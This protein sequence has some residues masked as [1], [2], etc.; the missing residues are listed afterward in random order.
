MNKKLLPVTSATFK[1]NIFIF[2]LLYAIVVLYLP[3]PNSQNSAALFILNTLSLVIFILSVLNIK[4]GLYLFIFFT[5]LLGS[6]P[7][8]ISAGDMSFILYLFFALFLGFFVYYSSKTHSK[9]YHDYN[10]AFVLDLDI[11]KVS[12][13]FIIICIAS[14]LV[15]IYRYANFVP[16]ITNF[17]H[18]LEVNINGT[19]ST[20]SILWTIDYFFSYIV[21]FGL[22][23][24]VFNTIKKNRDI[25]GA[26]IVLIIS[27]LISSGV[28][29]YQY[30]INPNLG[31]IDSW[32]NSGRFNATFTDPNALGAYGILLFP[33]FISLLI[34]FKKWYLKLMMIV[35]AIP[36]M[37]MIFLSGSRSIFIGILITILFL[38]II[39]VTVTVRKM[40]HYSILKKTLVLV[41]IS[42]I[43]LL[44]V[45]FASNYLTIEN[46]EKSLIAK[47]GLVDRSI[48]SL[49]TLIHYY[50][51]AG[52][53]ESLKS[54]SNFRYV[55]W[56]RAIEMFQDHK[57][58][59]VGVGSYIIELP[60][61]LLRNFARDRGATRNM[62]IDFTGNYYLQL[63]SELGA[64][65]LISIMLIF[66]LLINR[67]FRYFKQK[68]QEKIKN[69]DWLLVGFFLGYISMLFG[70]IFGP[71]TNFMEIQF[72][73]WLVIGLMVAY[74]NI[75]QKTRTGN[76]NRIAPAINITNKLRFN[77]V[78][79]VSFI[80]ITTVFA[81]SFFISSITTLS[82][83]VNQNSYNRWGEY[84]GWEN[85]YGF[86]NT[87]TSGDREYRLA[88]MDASEVLEKQGNLLIV[89][90]GDTYPFDDRL[91]LIVRIYVDNALVRIVK[92]NDK[93]WH[94]IEVEIPDYTKGHFT[95]TFVSSRS[96][97]P[98]E[99]GQFADKRENALVIGQ[100]RWSN[101]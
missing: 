61:Y 37:A 34:Y 31:S 47:S 100:Y 90:M 6:I 10:D 68:G 17:Y 16:F 28:V 2:L 88:K 92:L 39:G 77:L 53:V 13:L 84:K 71:H 41:S 91:P 32:V 74:I 38:I 52:L 8:I 51:S 78:S 99:Y 18:N 79:K 97:V 64:V 81:F 26:V 35:L 36:L 80:F 25:F 21:G 24:V 76:S 43:C 30:F 82:I 69:R 22:L 42:I 86:Y 89:P 23:L 59:G 101:Q 49:K 33:I 1:K 58:S 67:V 50:Q 48:D 20:A 66:Y 9:F 7:R 96:W 45:V 70:L 5:P 85:Y 98:S 19:T 83:N 94:D 87:E 15:T 62:D 56:G 29:F 93:I 40:R 11:T 54:I 63:L 55:Y 12:L 75:N 72:T 73:F 60:N 3:N 65:G 4:F 95:I 57:I 46:L 27:T 44:L 14:F